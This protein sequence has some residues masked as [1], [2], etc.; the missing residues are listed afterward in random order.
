MV[1]MGSC[2]DTIVVTNN[3]KK[4]P[5][6]QNRYISIVV[7]CRLFERKTYIFMGIA[8]IWFTNDTI[9]L[10]GYTIPDKTVSLFGRRVPDKTVSLFGRTIPGHVIRFF[11]GAGQC[12]I[13][14]AVIMF[15]LA[16]MRQ[17]RPHKHPQ[18]YS[19]IPFDAFEQRAFIDGIRTEFKTYDVA[20]SFMTAYKKEY[21]LYHFA[22]VSGNVTKDKQTIFKYI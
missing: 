6:N 5:L 22:L 13:L 7:L 19:V 21:P 15:A 17:A 9:L 3:L 11:N 18:S 2:S 1:A 14:M 12:V 20:W 10:F 4:I 16:W 8:A